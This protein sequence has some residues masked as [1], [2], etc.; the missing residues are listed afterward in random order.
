MAL[1]LAMVA[2]TPGVSAQD[3]AEHPAVGAWIID[4]T[5]EDATDPPELVTVAPG[6]II[7]NA[8]QEGAGYGS[9]AATG[10]RTADA[11][12]LF[13]FMDPEGAFVG[14]AMVRTSIEVAEDGQSFT[15]TYTFEPP[16][17]MAEAMGV[18]VGQLGPGEVTGQRVAVEPMGEPVGPIPEEGGPEPSAAADTGIQTLEISLDDFPDGFSVA[19]SPTT[20][21]AGEPITFAVTNTGVETHEV[22]LEKAGDADV[23]L[24]ADGVESEIEDIAPGATAELV[25]TITEPG[26]YQLACHIPG[27]Y[28]K[29]MVATFEVVE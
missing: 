19:I 2:A 7:V 4:A 10:D 11:T 8:G 27:H 17:G 24:S 14:F 3:T 9:W 5:P 6:G 12:F 1:L 28:E 29:G 22:V 16:A 15:G 21:K 18:P 23:P 26:T 13:P 25:W 20:V